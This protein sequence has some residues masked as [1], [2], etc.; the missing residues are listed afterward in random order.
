MP[1]YNV[2]F[3]AIIFFLT[4]VLVDG[5][6]NT[7]I[8][9]II[10]AAFLTAALFLFFGC[11]YKNKKFFL[12]A[13]LSLFIIVGT[14]YYSWYEQYQFKNLNIPFN[15]E[16][17]FIGLVSA[18]PEKGASQKLVVDLEKQ[19][20]G[21]IL[22]KTSPYP[23]FNY[24]DLIK[25]EGV[26]KQP[27]S[28]SYANYLAKDGIFGTTDFPKAEIVFTGQGNVVKTALFKLKSGIVDN[29]QKVLP[30]EKSAF[31]AGI[32]LGERAEFSKEFKEAMS[33]SG[34]THLVAL[35]GYN[36]SILVIAIAS[37]LGYLFSR[38]LTFWLT[39]AIILG[40]VL[41]TGAE[42][43]VVR[44]AI[45]GGIL[46]LAKQVG[47]LYSFKN[48]IAIAAFLM[49]LQNPK[50]LSFD[51]G[52]QLSFMALLGILYLMPAIKKFFRINE[53]PGLLSW[54]ENLLT[55]FSAQTAV[56]PL[57]IIYFGKFSL[58]SLLANLLILTIIPATMTLGFILGALGFVS[59]YL[60]LIF[61]WF[62]NFFLLYETFIIKFFGGLDILKI[63]S[64]SIPLSVFYYVIL[65]AFML[66]VRYLLGY[67]RN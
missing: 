23:S 45:M 41:M 49:V 25:F 12:L 48:A 24:G 58:L 17:E 4:G 27:E 56:A 62:V 54:R 52:F 55:T 39:L 50:V 28:E 67:H 15:Q 59:Y 29:F 43:S 21:R 64:L 53:E 11:F 7:S 40:F 10:G 5:G 31:L 61:G 33:N 1:L 65:V 3:Y 22:I 37:S 14:F 13:A 9:I 57:L 46:L 63:N 42:A 6:L 26:I 18:E 66:Y 44:A 16:T 60:S 47:R 34:T 38:R 20:R 51:I 19:Y 2:V 30:P 36:I 35:S 32:T 8:L